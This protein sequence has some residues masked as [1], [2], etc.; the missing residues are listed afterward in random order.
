MPLID[1]KF[2]VQ[3]SRYLLQCALAMACM[4]AVLGALDIVTDA[5]V[6][7]SLG[8]SSFI[9]FS[10]PHGNMSRTRY[11]VGGC[12]VGCTIGTGC[13]WLMQW[14]PVS[15]LPI[16]SPALYGSLAVALTMLI[17]VITNTEH[18]PA[19]GVALGL[20]VQQWSW[21]TVAATMVGIIALV[22]LRALL[23]PI[24]IRLV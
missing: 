7:A 24:L 10:I 22:V 21:W 19:A 14:A 15:F 16:S 17:M 4:L 6:V 12:V 23:R 8:A 13:F 2:R 5:V 20:V 18:P 1:R 9:V 11:L 3:K